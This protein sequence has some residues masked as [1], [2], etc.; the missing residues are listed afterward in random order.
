M[1]DPRNEPEADF[2]RAL[3]SFALALNIAS[4]SHSDYAQN[5]ESVF[6]EFQ[7]FLTRRYAD[8]LEDCGVTRFGVYGIAIRWP[9]TEGLSRGLPLLYTAHY[10][11]VPVD[12]QD[13]SVDPFSAEQKEGYIWGRGTLDT[14]N[15]LI[16]LME[17]AASLHAD[18]FTPRR[19]IWFAFGGDEETESSRGAITISRWFQEQGIRFAWTFDE[20]GIIAR[21][22]IPGVQGSAALVGVEEK[23]FVNFRLSAESSG[24][25]AST[26][27]PSTALGLVSRAVARLEAAR[28][29]RKLIPSLRKFF[30]RTVPYQSLPLKI[31]MANLWLFAPVVKQVLAGGDDSRAMI[32][33]TL[34][35]TM[36]GGSSKENVLPAAAWANINVRILPG[37]TIDQVR[38]RCIRII[39]DPRVEV[40]IANSAEAND[41]ISS[42]PPAKEDT[43][44]PG[45]AGVDR[46]LAFCADALSFR[47]GFT[48]ALPYL[49]TGATDSKHYA[50]ISDH[51]FRF[52]PME[53]DSR[54]LSRIHNP[55]ER[56]S[57]ENFRGMLAF[58]R[59]NLKYHERVF[60]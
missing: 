49:M 11:V 58:Y 19:D 3:D 39:R 59:Y 41:P 30:R 60:Q 44:S 28:Q 51:V 8:F 29:P 46:F 53:L 26:P 57:L 15:S 38:R 13:W 1:P 56:I 36:A 23:G 25:H 45:T 48:T 5:D 7:D 4:V 10:D 16:A 32:Q 35:P 31:V 33:S 50:H 34:A 21:N 37:E 6:Q 40:S 20:G 43:G 17:A 2:S 9:G 42:S 18:G 12:G 24:G 27:P 47:E 22:M 14:K 52:V 54:E 55:D